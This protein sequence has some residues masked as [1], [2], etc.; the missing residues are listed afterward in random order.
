MTKKLLLYNYY[1]YSHL[2][3]VWKCKREQTMNWKLKVSSY[4]RMY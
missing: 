1:R 3:G 4:K 2:E